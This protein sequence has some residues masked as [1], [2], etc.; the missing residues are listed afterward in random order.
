MHFTSDTQCEWHH[1]VCGDERR[2]D[3]ERHD[4]DHKTYGLDE[5]SLLPP[6]FGT[7]PTAKAGVC[8]AEIMALLANR[9]EMIRE[10]VDAELNH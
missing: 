8:T 4:G 10:C 3:D 2:R 7:A 1:H 6:P 5:T 9:I